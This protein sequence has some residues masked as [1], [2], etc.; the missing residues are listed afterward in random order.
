MISDHTCNRNQAVLLLL[1]FQLLE[2][3]KSNSLVKSVLMEF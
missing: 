1:L 2:R 3:K